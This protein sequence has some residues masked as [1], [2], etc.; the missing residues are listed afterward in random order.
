VKLKK[1]HENTLQHTAQ[2]VSE[3]TDTFTTLTPCR[4]NVEGCVNSQSIPP[5]GC[6]WETSSSPG[7]AAA[8]MMAPYSCQQ[9]VFSCET[10]FVM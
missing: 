6:H 2:I 9:R 7:I 8:S 4:C 3:G 1:L 10:T 5:S